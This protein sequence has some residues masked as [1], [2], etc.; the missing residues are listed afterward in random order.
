MWFAPAAG[1]RGMV[2]SARF[3][4]LGVSSLKRLPVWPE[5]PTVAEAAG[6][7]GF[8]ATAW[9]GLFAPARTPAPVIERLRA[10]TVRALQHPALVEHAASGAMMLVGSTPEELAVLIQ[11]ELVRWHRVKP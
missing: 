6:L 4:A 1:A 2:E 8:E 11:A 10:E 7:P 9:F 5:L 3:R